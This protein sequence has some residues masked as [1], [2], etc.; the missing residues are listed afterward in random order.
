M[1]YIQHHY[2]MLITSNMTNVTGSSVLPLSE[3][4]CGEYTRMVVPHML[5]LHICG[6]TVQ[7]EKIGILG[8]FLACFLQIL[9]QLKH[10]FLT[11]TWA[12][13]PCTRRHL[14]A[15]FDILR[16]SQS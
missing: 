10:F 4:V 2:N 6:I 12:H 7:V 15:K 8:L 16:P 11:P 14:C 3:V 9:P 13:H 5:F 1:H